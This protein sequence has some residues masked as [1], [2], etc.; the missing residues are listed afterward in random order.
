MKVKKLVLAM[1]TAVALTSFAGCGNKNADNGEEVTLKWVMPGAGMQKDSE[2]VFKTV[3]EKLKTYKGFENVNLDI[4]VYAS[5]DYLKKFLLLQTSGADMDIIQTYTLKDTEEIR[6][7]S[8]LALDD[9]IEKS[10]KLAD[11]FPDWLFDYARV[12]GKTWFVPNYQLLA[13]V[14][15]SFITKKDLSDQ[16]GD[17]KKMQDTF[18]K[19]DT[20][21]ESCWDA[22]EEYLET[23]S[24]NGKIGKGYMPLDSLTW[25][26]QKGYESVGERF[27]LKAGDDSHK[28]IYMDEMPER[29]H[30][31]KRMSDFFKKGYIRKDIASAE[32]TDAD[33]SGENGYVL[34]HSGLRCNEDLR[35]VALDNIETKYNIKV[36]YAMT[37]DYDYIPSYNA[38]GGMAISAKSKN[39]DSAFKVIELFNC[40]DGKDIYNMMV[41]GLEGTHYKKIGDNQ[42]EILGAGQGQATSTSN[43][44][45]WKWNTGNSKYA[46]NTANETT[47]PEL[48][49]EVNNGEHA[50]RSSLT[51][52]KLDTTSI[53]TEIAQVNTVFEEFKGLN[54]GTYSDVDKTYNEYMAK[55][56]KAGL[57]KVRTEI[58][59]QVDEFFKNKK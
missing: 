19:A 35:N 14:D 51:G 1:A 11:A 33:Y 21:D 30:A 31:F 54:L 50:V 44:G 13:N 20:F 28:I 22:M 36:D 32:S 15:Y 37:K 58:Q 41:Y 9:Y 27:Q 46:Y 2:L 4:T 7:G 59:K 49:D 39:P 38:A 8:F 26:L 23:L 3:N 57:E 56:Q 42:I 52:L 47:T 12:D 18:V 16:Y 40:E 17:M 53:T 24:E 55:L 5:G 10:D 43:Y 48:I 45:L 6:N 29:I 25:T 34:W